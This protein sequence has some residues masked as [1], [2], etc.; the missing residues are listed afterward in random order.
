M[1]TDENRRISTRARTPTPTQLKKW[2]AFEMVMLSLQQSPFTAS[3]SNK[4]VSR[5]NT[6]DTSKGASNAQFV[7]GKCTLFRSSE[8]LQPRLTIFFGIHLTV[9][10]HKSYY[11]IGKE[12]LNLNCTSF[13]IQPFSTCY[14][15]VQMTTVKLYQFTIIV[16]MWT[17][18]N[19]DGQKCIPNMQVAPSTNPANQFIV[20][21]AVNRMLFTPNWACIVLLLVSK[22]PGIYNIV[23]IEFV[24]IIVFRSNGKPSNS[25]LWTRFWR[26]RQGKFNGIVRIID[27]C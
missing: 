7:A 1:Q 11:T 23:I 3:S 24:A 5:P 15:T 4:C 25:W 9:I 22:T 14:S 20:Q 26:T 2:L 16:R 19:G 17:R 6:I 8:S 27:V 21:A 18:L 13:S 10:D 12:T